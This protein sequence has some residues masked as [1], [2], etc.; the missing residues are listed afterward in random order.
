[1]RKKVEWLDVR[2]PAI[3]DRIKGIEDKMTTCDFQILYIFDT[4]QSIFLILQL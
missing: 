2:A 1:M 3:E 4:G